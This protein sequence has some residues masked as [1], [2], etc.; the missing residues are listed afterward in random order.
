MKYL[1]T[2]DASLFTANDSP[3]LNSEILTNLKTVDLTWAPTVERKF[4]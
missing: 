3:L 2:A 1:L 4:K